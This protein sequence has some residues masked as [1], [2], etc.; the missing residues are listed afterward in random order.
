MSRPRDEGPQGLAAAADNT[1][2][3]LPGLR[4]LAEAFGAGLAATAKAALERCTDSLGDVEQVKRGT[5]RPARISL[6][7]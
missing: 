7:D 1:A 4:S 3:L 6:T 2:E 5:I